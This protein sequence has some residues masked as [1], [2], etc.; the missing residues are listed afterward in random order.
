VHGTRICDTRKPSVQG[1]PPP[2]TKTID[3]GP[4]Q[5][6]GQVRPRPGDYCAYLANLCDVPSPA[7]LPT[8]PRITT[9][10]T[11]ERQS[12]GRW[13]QIGF[14]CTAKA[15][16]PQVTPLLVLAEVRKLV[17]HPRIG[18]APP[19]GATL[20]NIQTLLWLDTP[21]DQSLGTVT[22]LGHR[23]MLRVHVDRV[24]WDF[25]DGQ[26]DTTSG[27]GH[28]Y[29][30]AEHC[31]TVTC[32]GY[33]G[34]IYATSG[35][36]TIAATATWSGQYRVDGG[37]WLDIAGTVTGPPTSTAITVRQA[38]GVLVPNPSGH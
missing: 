34:H 26:A 19:G 14:D 36:M 7:Q 2:V 20:V 30:P 23:V 5:I 3:C 4:P 6:S 27:P 31:R 33:W 21:A 10:V 1:S 22:L 38:R 17:P 8:D 16:A 28:R 12:D 35:T 32:D 13:T 37:A 18:V 11:L 29:D 24:G 25:G 15:E 9:Q